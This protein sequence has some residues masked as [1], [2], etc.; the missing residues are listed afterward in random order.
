MGRGLIRRLMSCSIAIIA[1]GLSSPAFAEL[2]GFCVAP[3]PACSDNGTIT[4]TPSDPLNFGFKNSPNSGVET[5]FFLEVLIPNNIGGATT[6]N[7]TI[8]G[9]NTGVASVSST[10]ISLT[11][12]TSG[13]L[14]NYLHTEAPGTYIAIPTNF[15]SLS[16]FLTPTTGAQAGSGLPAPTGY[17]AY[18]FDFGAVTFS[19]TT[20]PTFA[21]QFLFPLGTIITAYAVDVVQ[22]CGLMS[23]G[24]CT[25]YYYTYDWTKTPSSAALLETGG[26]ITVQNVPEPFTLPVLAAGLLGALAFRARF[27]RSRPQKL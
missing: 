1:I 27:R 10:L 16:S 7:F 25:K 13:F 19:A 6:A 18:A 20:D 12:W 11:A 5:D 15:N 26:G 23:G 14:S 22:H 3:S 2:H 21:T 8:N 24:V 4:P 9:T 17:Y